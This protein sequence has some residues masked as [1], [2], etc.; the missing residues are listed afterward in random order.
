MHCERR[1][2]ELTEVIGA[3]LSASPGMLSLF[4]PEHTSFVKPTIIRSV[5]IQ[6]A[7]TYQPLYR[8][9]RALITIPIRDC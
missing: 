4:Q 5:P 8:V 7:P 9:T 6:K 2:F 1:L 3:A